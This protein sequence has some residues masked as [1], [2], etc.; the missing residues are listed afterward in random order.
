MYIYG[1]YGNSVNSITGI[2]GVF[3]RIRKL[4]E[5]QNREELESRRMLV[6]KQKIVVCNET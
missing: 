2:V 5:K 6:T 3:K 4:L 1:Y